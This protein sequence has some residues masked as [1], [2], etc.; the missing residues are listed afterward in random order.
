M[1][2]ISPARVL[3]ALLRRACR[4]CYGDLAP[5]LEFGRAA[6]ATTG[7]SVA[8]N[9]A[10]R[11]EAEIYLDKLEAIDLRQLTDDL[12]EAKLIAAA[13]RLQADAQ[14]ILTIGASVSL[15]IFALGFMRLDVGPSGIKL[16]A[17]DTKHTESNFKQVFGFLSN[18]VERFAR[19]SAQNDEPK[20]SADEDQ[21]KT[22]INPEPQEPS[23]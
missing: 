6:S 11:A 20:Q 3:D 17:A 7:I 12:E 9:E 5:L 13:P 14:M 4:D 1:T 18:L 23:A 16:Q 8:D 21:A 19:G 22:S 15:I 10:E 2:E